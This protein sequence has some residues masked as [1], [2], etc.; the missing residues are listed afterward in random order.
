VIYA[1]NKVGTLVLEN[2]IKLTDWLL[3]CGIIAITALSTFIFQSHTLRSQALKIGSSLSSLTNFFN[4]AQDEVTLDR[5]YSNRAPA[6]ISEVDLLARNIFVMLT[7]IIKAGKIQKEAAVG[8]IVSQVSHDMRAP[9]GVFESILDAPPEKV[10]SLYGSVRE[11]LYRLNSMIESLRHS[12]TES[13]IKKAATQVEYKGL[14]EG[15]QNKA[16]ARNIS[17]EMIESWQSEIFVD[18]PKFER[19]LVN[20]VS[21]A[22]DAASSYVKISLTANGTDLVLRVCDDGP[23]VPND[24]MPRL[25]QRGATHGKHDG[26]GLGLAYVRQIMQGHGGDVVYLPEN[27]LTIFECRLPNAIIGKE[28][29]TVELSLLTE[30]SLDQVA[31]K[32]VSICVEPPSVAKEVLAALASR[33]SSKFTYNETYSPG[34]TDIIVTNNPE[35][36]ARILEEDAD[37]EIAEYQPT[38]PHE[39]LK[40]RLLRRFGS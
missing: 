28:E 26:T 4:H 24:F 10:P 35:V 3:I 6:N 5:Y 22:I 29:K 7:K 14:V 9:L 37:V 39:L 38:L 32:L 33:I 15:F 16:K 23:G 17:I 8:R 1:G 2:R 27:G 31:P 18:P 19:A 11:A 20:L 25:F 21:N 40:A 12:D 30:M 13:L 36:A 34:K